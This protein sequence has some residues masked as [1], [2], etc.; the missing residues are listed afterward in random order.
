MDR[1][2]E[3]NCYQNKVKLYKHVLEKFHFQVFYMNKIEYCG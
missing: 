3:K 1:S 2:Q